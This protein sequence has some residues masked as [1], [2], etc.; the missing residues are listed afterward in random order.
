M[1]LQELNRL[2]DRLKDEEAYLIAPKGFSLQ[3]ISFKI[4]LKPTGE[5]LSIQDARFLRGKRM[6]PSP[7]MVLGGAKPSGSGF[8]PCF[9]WD[10]AKY[11]LGYTEGNDVKRTAACFEASREKHLKVGGQIDSP[12]LKAVCR[13]LQ[14]WDPTCGKDH[15][16]L[17]ELGSGFGVFQIQGEQ[18]YVHEDPVIRQWWLDS[19][20]Q[21]EEADYFCLISGTKQPIAKTHN[22]IKGVVGAQSSGAAIVSFNEKAYESYG[23]D[24]SFNA[25]V[26]QES[27]FR[28]VTA[29]NALLDGPMREKHR[30]RLGDSTIAFWT[31]KPTTT[32]DVMALI[33][34]DR[35]QFSPDGKGQDES[36]RTKLAAYLNALRQGHQETFGLDADEVKTGYNLLGLAPNAAR[37]SVRFHLRGEL[38]E[39]LD[40]QRC[41]FAQ[42]AI[43]SDRQKNPEWDEFPGLR[44]LLDEACPVVGGKPDRDRLPPI[45]VG[46]LFRAVLS[47]SRYPDGFYHSIIGRLRADRTIRRTRAGFIKAYLIRN[48]G[49]EVSVSLDIQN[50]DPAYRLGRLFSALEKTQADA[51]GGDV[52]ATI[53]DRFYGAASANP[54]TVFPR[55]LR[56]YQHHLGKLNPG[57]RIHREKLI[58]EI[59]DPIEGFPAHFDL[60][61]QGLFAIGYYHQM[62]AFYTK[63]EEKDNQEGKEA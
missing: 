43:E 11:L 17:T 9:L 12:G 49:K 34:G 10:N 16:A 45:H 27:A 47:G 4:V 51:L 39:L 1:I 2:Y 38:G 31:D 33:L 14:Q 46:P 15:E 59:L 28:Y 37:I 6:I 36:L 42:M 57:Q 35:A 55:L 22:K 53:R 40:H 44:R 20:A 62:R 13:F 48:C 30:I 58:Q 5:L 63:S 60:T 32:E 61:A 23:A 29:L 24:Q 8:N 50:P 52:N 21:A 19:H 54:R 56:T 3:K 41:H 7:V 26:G 25:P 18:G